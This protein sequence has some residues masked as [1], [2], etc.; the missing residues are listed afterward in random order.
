[1]IVVEITIIKYH[2]LWQKQTM[3][4]LWSSVYW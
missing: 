1:M 2:S 3:S 4:I